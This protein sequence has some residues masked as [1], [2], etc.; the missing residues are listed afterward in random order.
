FPPRPLSMLD[1]HRILTN[2]CSSI[3]PKRFMERGCAVCGYLTKLSELTLLSQYH[4]DLDLLIRDEATRREHFSSD[5]PIQGIGGPVLAHGCRHVCVECQVSLDN[6]IV[7]KLALARHN[8]VGEVPDVLKDLTFAERMMVAKIRHNRCVVRVNS[9]RVRM[10]ANAIMFSQPILKVMLKLPPSKLEMNEILAF[11]YTGSEA[12]TPEDFERTPMLVRRQKVVDSLNWLKLNHEGY[13]ELEISEENLS[14]YKERDVPVVVD[15]QRTK[16]EPHDSVPTAA[17]AVN[18]NLE[19]QGT[20]SGPCTF[21]VHG[22]TG[23]EYSSA[24]MHTIKM[25]ALQHLTN[26]G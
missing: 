26:Q 11:V 14:T 12:P 24:P 10:S 22:L 20:S 16:E 4:G 23:P 8:W 1:T 3:R 15:F 9:G 6:G 2:Y 25:I 5:D 21:A 7:P 19:E 13:E 17:R 18:V